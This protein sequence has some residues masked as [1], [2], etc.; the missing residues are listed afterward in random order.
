MFGALT[1]TE[2]TGAG[3]LVQANKTQVSYD[4]HSGSPGNTFYVLCELTLNLQANLDDLERVCENLFNT[5]S[6]CVKRLV[7]ELLTT[8]HPPAIPPA[9]ISAGSLMFPVSLSVIFPRT[10]SFTVSLIAFSGA[11]PTS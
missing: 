6:M 5:I 2:Q 7:G 11:T 1:V 9:K 4:P 10:R 8:W 3:S